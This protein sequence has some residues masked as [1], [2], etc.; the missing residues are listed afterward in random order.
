MIP[1][2]DAQ[3]IIDSTLAGIV[4]PA[5]M[6]PVRRALGRT[7]LADQ[8]SRLDLPPF[9]KSAVDG[10]AIGPGEERQ[11]YR[12]VATVMAGETSAAALEPG[13]TVKVMT[14]APVP[15]GA[16]RIVMVEHTREEGSRVRIVKSSGGTNLCKQAEDVRAGDC[17]ATAGT[18]LRAP[19]I[20]SFISAGITEVQ[21]ARP[22]RAVVISTG[23]EIADDPADLRPGRI[24]NSNGPLLAGLM[25]Q[26]DMTLIRELSIGDDLAETRE[27]I[28]AGLQIADCV[29]LSGGVSVGDRDFVPHAMERA[30]L[31]IRFHSVAIKPGKPTV[32]ATW[33]RTPGRFAL[34]L[35]GN[36]M[37]V[38]LGFHLFVRRAQAIMCGRQPDLRSFRLPLAEDFIRRRAV[39]CEFVPSRLTEDGTV[40]AVAYHGSA[41]LLAAGKADG[42]FRVP[43]GTTGIVQG[44]QVEFLPI[45]MKLSEPNLSSAS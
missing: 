13:T 10:Y 19:D 23:D 21:V 24:M 36:P 11:E 40:K 43:I 32:Y 3:R 41:H 15:E 17:I 6:M 22:L 31:E 12:L 20:A 37:A 9:D 7:I 45:L 4:S 44:D 26:H 30:G 34:G 2:E 8:I 39:R 38:L 28:R 5:E 25:A 42:F 18:I 1:L 33:P 14:G 29:I 35:P 16:A 27:A